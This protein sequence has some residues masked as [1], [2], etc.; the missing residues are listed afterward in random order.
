MARSPPSF[1]RP[2]RSSDC[3][4]FDRARVI[5]LLQSATLDGGV[6]LVETIVAGQTALT[7]EELR[8]QYRGWSISV[9]REDSAS[10]NVLRPQG[11]RQ[12]S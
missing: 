8:S 11:S 4:D 9:E 3:R 2:P 10:P 5:E 7:I 6:H 1:A 12:S